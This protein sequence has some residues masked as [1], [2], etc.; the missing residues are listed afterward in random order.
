MTDGRISRDN[1][2]TKNKN[3]SDVDP[4]ML[5]RLYGYSKDRRIRDERRRLEEESTVLLEYLTL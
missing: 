1:F 2:Q 4:E 3:I 5:A